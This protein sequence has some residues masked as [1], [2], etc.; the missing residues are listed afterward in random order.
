M[1][2]KIHEFRENVESSPLST[3]LRKFVDTNKNGETVLNISDTA[4]KIGSGM[5]KGGK[6][7]ESL[8][9]IPA[10][11]GAP[12]IKM[13]AELTGKGLEYAG[14]KLK[15]FGEITDIKIKLPE[16]YS[17][18]KTFLAKLNKKTEGKV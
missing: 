18:K 10:L 2:G 12:K 5:E 16:T 3:K 14:G 7:I 6:K 13:A 15:K 9:G 8:K 11:K 1:A 4:K 17:D